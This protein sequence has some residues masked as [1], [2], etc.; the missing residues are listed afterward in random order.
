VLD[1]NGDRKLEVI[2]NS[3]YYEG[4]ETTVYSC[5]ADKLKPCSRSSAERERSED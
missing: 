1:L 4:G 3:F 2:V 5:D